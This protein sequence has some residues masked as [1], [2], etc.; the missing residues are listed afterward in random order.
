MFNVH[1][2]QRMLVLAVAAPPPMP[3]ALP[4]APSRFLRPATQYRLALV[5]STV[6][7]EGDLA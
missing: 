7:P 6:T 2:L 4:P 3:A 5:P 1:R